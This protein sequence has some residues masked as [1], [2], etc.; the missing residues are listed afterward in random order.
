MPL[1]AKRYLSILTVLLL[2]MSAYRLVVVPAIEP[3]P[4][5]Q[6]P[7]PKFS[8]VLGGQQWWHQLFPAGS[9][10]T[11]NPTIAQT[12]QGFI[13]L[14][15]SWEQ[16]GPKTWEL[17][18]LTLILPQS[19]SRDGT[20]PVPG[21][22]ADATQ[23]DVWIVN[24]AEG[25][26]IHFEHAFD[27]TGGSIPSL[28]RGQLRGA[29]EITR[30]SPGGAEKQPWKLK[31]SDLAIDRRRITTQQ[32]VTIEWDD[33]IIR[34]RDLRIM[35]QRDVL[36]GPSRASSAWGPL[37]EMEL[38][39]VDEI[40]IALPPGG[41]WASF[42]NETLAGRPE[43]K[44]LP[45]R[46]QA[47]CAG[48][49]VF[50]F[51][52]STASLLNG[53]HIVHRLGELPPDEFLSQKVAVRIEP[54]NAPGTTAE[55]S[56]RLA[57][58]ELKELEATGVDSLKNFVGE[59]W[60]E[61]KAPTID[62]SARG[63]H[64][65]VDFVR[66]RID[67]SGQLAQPGATQS[68]ARLHYAGYEFSSPYIQYQ[69]ASNASDQPTR[70]LGWL[71]A[72]G[73]GE[74]H[75][76]A[77]GDAEA[78]QARWQDTLKMAPSETEGEQ[79]VELS[80][81]TF[82]ES[83]AHGFMTSDRIQ[84]WL[85]ENKTKNPAPAPSTS[86]TDNLSSNRYLPHRISAHGN[87]TVATADINARVDDMQLTMVY[88]DP[89]VAVE[90]VQAENLPAKNSSGPPAEQPATRTPSPPA[91]PTETAILTNPSLGAA[92]SASLPPARPKPAT[93]APIHQVSAK[94]GDSVRENQSDPQDAPVP[95]PITVIGKSMTSS[96][97]VAGEET[98]ID[99]LMISGP[100]KVFRDKP[101][102][103]NKIPPWHVEGDRL[104]LATNAQ[105]Q[106]DM[107]VD[108]QPARIV[109]AE[110]SLEGPTIRFDQLNNLIWMDQPGEF[111]IP[112]SVLKSQSRT[113]STLTWLKSPHCTWQGRMLFDGSVVRIEGD[114]KLDGAFET[115]P[116]RIWWVNAFS[117]ALDITLASAID[118]N[119]PDENGPAQLERIV[120]RNDVNIFASQLD[121]LGN[122]KSRERMVVPML[123]FY[124]A[125]N[126]IV[127]TGPG[128]MQSNHL[129][130]RR[131]GRLTADSQPAGDGQHL[132]GSYLSYRD[133]LVGFLDRNE[134]IF[135]GKVELAAG[136]LQS[137]DDTIDL[138]KMQ[139]LTQGQ[140]LLNCDQLKL[141]D[142]SGLSSTADSLSRSS[143]KSSW[144]FQATGKVA[145]Q[146]K[147]ESGDYLGNGYQVTYV[148]AKEQL[149]LR[150]DGR[151]AAYLKSEPV[152]TTRE[153]GFEAHVE[154]AVI[155]PRTL[156]IEDFRM[157]QAGVHFGAPR[158]GGPPG[159]SQRPGPA[160]G[161]PERPRP[162][163]RAGVT[164]F[165]QPRRP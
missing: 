53:V 49:F 50:D 31:T 58:I 40:N 83:K 109:V 110:G 100:L 161:A 102:A 4:R 121:A 105:G 32:T 96:V 21:A 74:L 97:I 93:T 7:V 101:A 45:A 68:I 147:A 35:L 131:I 55:K 164:D 8:G 119:A 143:A 158:P 14:S 84:V 51:T 118:L 120:L 15:S 59:K 136:P 46:L 72:D 104:Q 10:E 138:T 111:T 6:A 139:R 115:A 135:E 80:G 150:G 63:K 9:W 165:F 152:D 153:G 107:Q 94:A 142:T 85:R 103:N 71:F 28:E 149:F 99:N 36:G 33:S 34:G 77:R 38:Y 3:P 22:P 13:L 87:V 140:M 144:E 127:G 148:Q 162:D 145:F 39:H 129:S 37:E 67:L 108:G 65:K 25:A 141:V 16:V 113:D 66:K 23:K 56:V 1:F 122:T 160:G 73:P 117:Q 29:V 154:S 116:D 64:L 133:S 43:L 130:K 75:M 54:P 62:A 146:G 92:A 155:N 70:K 78:A 159:G 95:D 124:V 61:L 82:V 44:I 41:I 157:G 27:L 89:Q 17:K 48:R 163:P 156:A 52:T 2:A 106:A 5:P 26:T 19:K 42:D 20:T 114:I 112:P 91:A 69:S 86:S 57:G 18:P 90:E 132:Q 30:Q 12:K 11:D 24:A 134:I 126:Q 128:W 88:A 60:V 47:H 76:L 79:W 125:K 98:W 151:N 123:T 81:N 137:W